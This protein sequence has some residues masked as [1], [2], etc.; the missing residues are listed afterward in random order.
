MK[1]IVGGASGDLGTRIT[2]YLLEKV[3]PADLILLSRSPEKLEWS[4][5]AGAEVRQGDYDKPDTLCS[6]LQG[7]D[8]FLVIS[9]LS[10][11]RRLEQHSNAFAAAKT[12]GIKHLVYTSSM[13][14]QPQTPS[15]SGQEHYETEQKLL[16]TGLTYTI[17]RNGWYA[18]VVPTLI[19]K[20]SMEA[21]ALV[22]STGDGSSIDGRGGCNG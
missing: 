4:V 16:S 8:I 20:P 19:M 1:I 22:S 17:L 18:D 10:I 9:T 14:I 7:G 12:A 2:R 5:E 3:S 15:L 13:G 6:A 21:G 11:G